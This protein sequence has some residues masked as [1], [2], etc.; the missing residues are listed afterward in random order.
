MELTKDL[1]KSAKEFKTIFEE[2]E[3]NGNF[4]NVLDTIKENRDKLELV[5]QYSYRYI[6]DGFMVR[7]RKAA[8]VRTKCFDNYIE[9]VKFANSF[10]QNNWHW[11]Q[12]LNDYDLYVLDNVSDQVCVTLEGIAHEIIICCNKV[13]ADYEE[14]KKKES[15]DNRLFYVV[16][17]KIFN[18]IEEAYNAT[19]DYEDIVTCK[20]EKAAQVMAERQKKMIE[21]DCYGDW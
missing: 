17:G 11:G 12:V 8:D 5:L 16:E 20:G 6:K 2:I 1:F 13:I 4:D 21:N 7:Y 15:E 9:A 14:K 10:M 18:D 19:G 3:N